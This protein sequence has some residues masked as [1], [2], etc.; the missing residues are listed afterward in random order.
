M[1]H[2]CGCRDE[3]LKQQTKTHHIMRYS[4]VTLENL[5]WCLRR[6]NVSLLLALSLHS[7]FRGKLSDLVHSLGTVDFACA[8]TSAWKATILVY[9]KCEE[10]HRNIEMQLNAK[11][12]CR[13]QHS[14]N[15][16]S[17]TSMNSAKIMFLK[18]QV[19]DWI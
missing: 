17:R 4:K 9:R 19:T 15:N 11:H 14:V 10:M 12:K 1:E 13:R 18:S 2:N 3:N 8:A 16:L 7:I 6:A 5:A